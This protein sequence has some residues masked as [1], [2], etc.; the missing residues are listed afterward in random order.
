[1][2]KLDRPYDSKKSAREN[3][4]V[5][6]AALTSPGSVLSQSLNGQRHTCSLFKSKQASSMTNVLTVL[7]KIEQALKMVPA[8]TNQPAATSV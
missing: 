1:M 8:R 7:D 6:K 4:E 3:Y 2:Y 5:L